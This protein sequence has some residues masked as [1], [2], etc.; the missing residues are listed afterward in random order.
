VTRVSLLAEIR[1]ACAEV[2]ARA[3]F[4]TIDETRI[5]AYGRSLPL[6]GAEVSPSSREHL[7]TG[8]LE[9][10]AAFFLILDAINFGS[11]W[12]P[13]L[14]TEGNSG[15]YTIALGLKRRFESQ[16]EWSAGSLTDIQASELAAV[17]D[18]DEEHPLMELFAESLHDLGRHVH[19]EFGGSYYKVV[20]S[21][22]GSAPALVELLAAWQSFFDVSEYDG[23]R[24][25]FF[26]RAQIAAS[27]IAG[28]G[29]AELGDLDQLTMFADNLVP[30]VLRLDGVLDYSPDLAERIERDVPI[31][32]GS[33]EE[34]EIRACALHAVELLSHA[35][36]TP[37][38]TLDYVLWNRGQ[39]PSYKARPRHRSPCTA[40]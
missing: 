40:Y 15:Y 12:F 6:A 4:V 13:T 22:A 36:A 29:V 2:A 25:P 9:E 24:V 37:A 33:P 30:H 21:A 5:E 3:R 16:G 11:G 31:E 20:E 17:F 14:R 1:A 10:R 27:D 23:L 26:K 28:A 7:L 32:H 19:D 34:V 38:R 18:Q 39:E 35:T 8:G